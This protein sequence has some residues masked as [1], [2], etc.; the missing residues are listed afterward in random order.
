MSFPDCSKPLNESLVNQDIDIYIYDSEE[1]EWSWSECRIIEQ[2][3][4]RVIKEDEEEV[5]LSLCKVKFLDDAE[6]DDTFLCSF[7][8]DHLV[9][10]DVNEDE[11]VDFTWWKFSNCDWKPEIDDAN[12][13]LL[14]NYKPELSSKQEI[15]EFIEEV[16]MTTMQSDTVSEKMK[17]LDRDAMC[18]VSDIIVQ[19][20][21][22]LVDIIHEFLCKKREDDP[23]YELKPSDFENLLSQLESPL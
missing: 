10:F 5:E 6:N 8:P 18:L 15:Q 9:I 14:E 4:S 11:D 2:C 23:H 3:E 1:D 20:K 12:E 21:S 7:L 17:N 16:L 13:H 19:G 22:N